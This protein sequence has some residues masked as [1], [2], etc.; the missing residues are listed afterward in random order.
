MAG[1]RSS[2]ATSFTACAGYRDARRAN[3]PVSLQ[4]LPMPF[5][6]HKARLVRT[7]ILRE[8][9]HGRPEDRPSPSPRL[10]KYGTRPLADLTLRPTFTSQGRTRSILFCTIQPVP[11]PDNGVAPRARFRVTPRKP[12]LHPP[13]ARA[14]GEHPPA[15]PDRRCRGSGGVDHRHGIAVEIEVHLDDV[16]RRPR[17]RRDDRDLAPRERL[18]S[19]DLPAFGGPAIATTRPSRSRSLRPCAASTSAISASRP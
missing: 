16:P 19:V 10:A 15:R 6:A 3:G 7:K 5:S 13:L 9:D 11:S 14:R 18:I 12:G 17:K 1:G 4:Q 2:S 8:D